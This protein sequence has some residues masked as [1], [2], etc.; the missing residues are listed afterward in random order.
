MPMNY[1]RV[2]RSYQ[3][4]SRMVFGNALLNAQRKALSN[5]S[6][7]CNILMIGGGD[8]EILK[9]LSDFE[10]VLDF[11]EISSEMVLVAQSKTNFPVSWH[12]QDIFNF[13]TDRKYDVIFMPFLLD[14]F[15]T[16][17]CSELI[18]H[19]KPMLKSG[20]QVI[21]VDFTEK[22]NLWQKVLLFSMYTFF[23]LIAQVEAN[24]IP[25]IERTM[26]IHKL[27]KTLETKSFRGFIE[28]KKYSL[29][30]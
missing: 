29:N 10:G 14:N 1:G 30:P 3:F 18:T 19:L 21:V 16:K 23:G 25:D 7:P 28:I 15:T 17:Q 4:L 5:L 20:G 6:F 11:V 13:K 24:K 2:A 9:H 8:G 26:A 22:P 27:Q 12:V